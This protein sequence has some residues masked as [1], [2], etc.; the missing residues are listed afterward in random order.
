MQTKE[1]VIGGKTFILNKMD[2]E[3]YQKH[4]ALY[5]ESIKRLNVKNVS[6]DNTDALIGAIIDNVAEIIDTIGGGSDTAFDLICTMMYSSEFETFA[7]K[8]AFLYKNMCDTDLEEV[9]LFFCENRLM[10]EIQKRISLMRPIWE[11]VKT[12]FMEKIKNLTGKAPGIS[13][14][15]SVHDHGIKSETK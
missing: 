12:P 11:K 7:D 2:V 1:V 4:A 15:L 9:Q 8:K 14:D 6:L 10:H 3:N 13:S 5:T